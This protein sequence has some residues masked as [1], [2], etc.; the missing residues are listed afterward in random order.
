MFFFC[1]RVNIRIIT[2]NPTMKGKS[3]GTQHHANINSS[4]TNKHGQQKHNINK[5]QI[6]LVGYI[7][8]SA[9]VLTHFL[10]DSNG[11]ELC[12]VK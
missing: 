3:I 12:G 2:N 7:M 10:S 4:A 5:P 9:V 11:S 8:I 1:H 6:I